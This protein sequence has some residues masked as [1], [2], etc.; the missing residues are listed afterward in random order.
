MELG[1]QNYFAIDK[2][3]V[4]LLNGAVVDYEVSMSREGFVV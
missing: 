4:F 1:G 2:E 3:S